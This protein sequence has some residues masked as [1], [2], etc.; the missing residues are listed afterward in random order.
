MA[1]GMDIGIVQEE[2]GCPEGMDRDE[3]TDGTVATIGLVPRANT[4]YKG[5]LQPPGSAQ[6]KETAEEPKGIENTGFIGDPPPYSPPDPKIE[7]LLYPQYQMNCMGQMPVM[8]QP[9]PAA[10]NMYLHQ[11]LPPGSYPYIINDGSL[12]V[13][14]Q[15][16]E[17]R[18]KDYMVESVLVMIFCCFLTGIVAVVYSHETRAALGRG[19]L[20]QA[21]TSSRKARSLVLFSL[22]FGVFMSI[23][24][25]IYVVVA[26]F[27]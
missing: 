24:W 21:Q 23:S 7:H 2:G 26:I 5:I 20:L 22:L 17:V 11:N 6:P 15:R 25:I 18:T 16:A 27:L 9:G 10:Q 4:P 1:T 8:Y 13:S 12:G 14:P 19:D 3:V